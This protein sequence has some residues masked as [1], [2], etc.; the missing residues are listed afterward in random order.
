MCKFAF[1]KLVRVGI[2]FANFYPALYPF[3]RALV[4]CDVTER[5]LAC[6]SRGKTD[7]PAGT[8]PYLWGHPMNSLQSIKGLLVV[9]LVCSLGP[10]VAH[11]G[12]GA[13]VYGCVYLKVKPPSSV[14]INFTPVATNCMQDDAKGNPQTMQASEAGLTCVLIGYIE[15]KGSGWCAFQDSTWSLGYSSPNNSWSGST[16]STFK[17]G[18]GITLSNYSAG[19]SVSTT[20]AAG[21]ATGTDWNDQGPIYIVFTP[22]ATASF[23]RPGDALSRLAAM[24]TPWSRLGRLAKALQMQSERSVAKAA[25]R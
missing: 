22:D 23:Q 24:T 21:T 18:S 19:T 20:K 1:I 5:M 8:T 9:A 4:S 14:T 12:K 17:T 2:Y 7:R 3:Q 16:Q 15:A 13:N 25:Y 10:G 6:R 11:A